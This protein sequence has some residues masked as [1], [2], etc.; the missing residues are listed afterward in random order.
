L[1]AGVGPASILIQDDS[2]ENDPSDSFPLVM[3]WLAMQFPASTFHR[4]LWDDTS[5]GLPRS[6]Y[7]PDRHGW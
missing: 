1:K 2:T 3:G 7:D 5:R 6:V 4:R